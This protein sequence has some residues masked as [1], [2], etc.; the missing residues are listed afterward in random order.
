MAKNTSILL[1]DHSKNFIN[2]EVTSGRYNSTSKVI[3]TA[4]RLF[5]LKEQ[6]TK[7]LCKEPELDEKGAMVENFNLKKSDYIYYKLGHKNKP[8]DSSSLHNLKFHIFTLHS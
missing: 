4:L 2:N 1:E 5:K 7:Q 6:K 8:I 3:R